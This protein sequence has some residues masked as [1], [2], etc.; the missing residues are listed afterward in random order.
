MHIRQSSPRLRI[1]HRIRHASLRASSR[2]LAHVKLLQQLL[3]LLPLLLNDLLPTEVALVLPGAQRRLI[4][5]RGR[6][7]VAHTCNAILNNALR[8]FAIQILLLGRKTLTMQRQRAVRG[9]DFTFLTSGH[10]HCL[11][12]KHH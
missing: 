7:T 8:A 3:L 10:R 9:S 4:V 5:P 6:P 1:R 2:I 12:I 11:G